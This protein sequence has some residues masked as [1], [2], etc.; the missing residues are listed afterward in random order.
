MHSPFIIAEVS[1]NHMGRL[2]LALKLI[3]LAAETGA[4]AVKFQTYSPATITLDSDA[5]AFVVQEGLWKGRRLHDLYEE[6]QTPFEWHAALFARA[7]ERGILAFSAPFDLTAVDLLESLD[8]PLYKIAS[9]ELVDI[10]LIERV[11]ATGKPM[12]MSTGMAT[13]AEIDEAVKTAKGA[14]AS[15]ITLLH[16]ISGYPTPYSDC[17]LET[18]PDLARRT[19]LPVG[20][21]DHTLGTAIPIAATALGAT[22]IEKHFCHS[23]AAGAVDS[24]FSLEPDEMK[25]MV[26]A[27]RQV[28]EA[29]TAP[30]YGPTASEADSLR[31]RRSLYIAEDVKAGEVFSARNLRS[32]R[33]SGGLHTRYL[34]GILG[35]AATRDI[36]A[37]TPLDWTMVKGGEG[38]TE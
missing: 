18:I 10:G 33:P 32:V 24:A 13:L 19:G 23:R 26:T 11:A 15:D 3:D 30:H 17:H 25:A 20:I 34:E 21:S 1:G 12:I 28:A 2:D 27:C 36:V 8:C 35:R 9:C 6:A 7:R 31:F 38:G 29:R 16:C 14:G 22:V 4:N 37:G 5:P